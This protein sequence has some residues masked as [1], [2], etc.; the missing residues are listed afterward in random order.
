MMEN[1]PLT[2][3]SR[4]IS[5]GVRE[6]AWQSVRRWGLG[7]GVRRALREIRVCHSAGLRARVNLLGLG[8]CCNGLFYFLVYF[9]YFYL[10]WARAKIWAL[11]YIFQKYL[12][13]HILIILHD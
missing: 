6:G 11:Q 8:H 2:A 7:R 5:G 10:S 1:H 9:V 4:C 13:A 3:R 12:S